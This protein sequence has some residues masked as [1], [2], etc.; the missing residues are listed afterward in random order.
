M[1]QL[2]TL[3]GIDA[4]IRAQLVKYEN[5]PNVAGLIDAHAKLLSYHDRLLAAVK[6]TLRTTPT[7]Y[8]LPDDYRN[9]LERLKAAIAAAE[10]PS[11]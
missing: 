6:E 1:N 8:R 4:Q 3:D 5:P 7:K 11:P 9:A 10:E 2:S